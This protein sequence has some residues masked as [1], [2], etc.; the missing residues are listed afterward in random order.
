MKQ[1]SWKQSVNLNQWLRPF[2]AAA[3]PLAGA[4][5]G[6]GAN[7]RAA[8]KSLG[9]DGICGFFGPDAAALVPGPASPR[10]APG[11][12][13]DRM[14]AAATIGTVGPAIG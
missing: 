1:P 4:S 12:P 6:G 11:E 3:R 8:Q 9:K 7:G 13:A 5:P 14:P 2:C 10:A